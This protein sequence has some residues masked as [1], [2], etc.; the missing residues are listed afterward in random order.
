MGRSTRRAPTCEDRRTSER[1]SLWVWA[2]PVSLATTPGMEWFRYLR[3]PPWRAESNKT[4]YGVLFSSGY[5]DVSVPQVASTTLCIQVAVIRSSIG[6]G[7]P[8]RKSPDQRLLATSPR[9]IAGCYVLH[10]RSMPRHPPSALKLR[11]TTRTNWLRMV[12]TKECERHG[13]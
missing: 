6:L 8:I 7:Y 2:P 5:L 3:T 12:P 4:T 11:L 1:K 13:T 10:R 9:L